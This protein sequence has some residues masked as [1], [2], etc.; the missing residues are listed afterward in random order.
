MTPN[1]D[2]FSHQHQ[3]YFQSPHQK[4]L[5]KFFD[6]E[7]EYFLTL[8]R[9]TVKYMRNCMRETGY[10]NPHFYQVLLDS[11]PMCSSMMKNY[12]EFRCYR[13]I[14]FYW[15]FFLNPDRKAF[16]NY[17]NPDSKDDLEQFSRMAAQLNWGWEEETSSFKVNAFGV[18]SLRTRPN[19]KQTDPAT[20]KVTPAEFLPIHR[21]PSTATPSFYVPKPTISTEDD[22]IY[23]PNLPNFENKYGQVL[24]QRDSELLI[25]YLTVPYLR[26]PLI[27]T[28][29]ST[30]DRIHKL[31][32]PELR[33]ILDSVLFEPSKYLRMDMTGKVFRHLFVIN[34]VLIIIFIS[35]IHFRDARR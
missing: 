7:K 4:T 27:L 25:S 28:F 10:S 15:K 31:Q 9:A 30:E 19:P 6:W 2:I 16:P 14:V 29:F 1:N 24:N 5:E 18:D 17:M 12:P 34:N 22:V 11:N 3:D 33:Q 23:R 13:D 21:F 35:N 20:G 32:S 8:D 26:L